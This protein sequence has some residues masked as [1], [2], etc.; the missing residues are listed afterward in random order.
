MSAGKTINTISIQLQLLLR[1]INTRLLASLAS[2]GSIAPHKA[3]GNPLIAE[4][5]SWQRQLEQFQRQLSRIGDN[6]DY[7]ER[8][9]QKVPRAQ[10]YRERQSIG[11]TRDNL[12]QTEKLAAVVHG[13]LKQLVHRMLIPGDVEAVNKSFD[14]LAD[15]L[16]ETRELDEWLEKAARVGTLS[17]HDVSELRTVISESKASYQ[18]M[19]LPQAAGVDWLL[20]L[21]LFVRV[22]HIVALKT[23]AK[24]A[25]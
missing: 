5:N 4:L 10:R 18:N 22:A 8:Y 7:R 3:S 13:R 12:E 17:R 25:A 19:P 20:M 1:K 9:V 14:L 24:R 6:L 16:K 15:T 11:S 23:L 2:P 21:T